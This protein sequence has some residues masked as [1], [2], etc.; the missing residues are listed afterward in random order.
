MLEISDRMDPPPLVLC[1]V[2]SAARV[3]SQRPVAFFMKG[4]PNINSTD[5]QEQARKRFPTLSAFENIYYFPLRMDELYAGT[6]LLTWYK[7][8]NP[9]KEMYWIHV[10]SDACRF[11][12]MWKYGGLYMDADVISMRPIPNKN[13]LAAE[14]FD[15]CS[16][17]VFGLYPQHKFT[18][19]C[20]EDFVKNY[21]GEEWGY[22]GPGL[23]TRVVD[24]LCGMPKFKNTADA[25]CGD[26]AYLHP[27]RFYPITWS[28]WRRYFEVWNQFPTFDD[29]YSLHLWNFMNKKNEQ[30]VVT[31]S[32]TLVEHLFKQYCPTT[33]ASLL[34]N[35]VKHL[36]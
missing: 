19:E 33:Y 35:N 14:T 7:K 6:P 2:E 16:S 32:N 21:R 25:L 4:L 30:T 10:S 18:W 11:A 8:I 9:E 3:Y 20:M 28:S 26:I 34:N 29:S 1:S 23:F 5:Y 13:F 22:Q 27:Q 12:A 17:S 15:V 24:R 36:Q 31:G